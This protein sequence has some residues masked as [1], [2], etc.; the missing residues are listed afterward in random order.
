MDDGRS[1][2]TRQSIGLFTV[3]RINYTFVSSLQQ[4]MRVT[5]ESFFKW[6]NGKLF[7]NCCQPIHY[8]SFLRHYDFL[9]LCVDA[10][11]RLS[12]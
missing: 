7:S 8:V 4:Y 3:I 6:K 5:M 1:P 2:E 12:L 9:W 10:D 11:L